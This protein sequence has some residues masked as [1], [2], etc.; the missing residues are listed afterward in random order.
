VQLLA[1]AGIT[2]VLVTRTYLAL[3][4]YPQVGGGS[5]HIAHVLWGG[6][7]ML[8]GLLS[9]LL[10]AGRGAR[11]WTALLGGIGLGLFVDEVG[12]FVTLKNDYFFRP[13]AAIIYLVFAGLL[14]LTSQMGRQRSID[15]GDRLANAAQIA[16]AGLIS[17]LTFEQR[18]SAV[19]LLSGSDDEAGRA[20]HQ[21]L[22]VARTREHPG[23]VGRLTRRPAAMAAWLA[24]QR[25][26]TTI[27]IAL[28]VVSRVL[29]ATIFVVQALVLVAGHS[30]DPGTESGAII[31]SAITRTLSASLVIVGLAQWR[32]NWR[33]A[34]GWFK[35]AALVG[36]LVTQVFNFTD[37]QFR[38]V[39]E[40]PFDL[41]VLALVS[42]QLQR[43]VPPATETGSVR[44]TPATADW[45]TT[46]STGSSPH[47]PSRR[48]TPRARS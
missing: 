47:R 11:A 30:P 27:V 43:P 31:A 2:T 44:S 1:V 25:W 19:R 10:F 37:S 48:T 7:L 41:L 32:R 20:V 4:G 14:V 8:A 42:Y 17:G 16:A 28:F 5:L 45:P 21:L 9:A 26:F 6:L 15:P 18:Q 39:A 23:L 13:A 12:K 46:T 40:L 3:T 35:T 38:A 36:L 34:Y 29:V 22:E 24:D 33:A